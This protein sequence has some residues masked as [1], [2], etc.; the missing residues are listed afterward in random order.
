MDN[1]LHVSR[2]GG[3]RVRKRVGVPKKAV[4]RSVQKA[5]EQGI[6]HR[7]ATGSL[8]RYLA[9]LYNKYDGN[10]NNIRIYSDK[11][12]VFHDEILITVLDLPSIYR[13]TMA[14]KH[15]KAKADK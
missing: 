15:R 9:M 14:G 6:D 13:K 5:L 2:H 3:K 4:E 1:A 11:V 8:K 10:G 7:T 12:Y